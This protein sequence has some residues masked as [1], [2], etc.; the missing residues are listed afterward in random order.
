MIRRR[1]GDEFFLI[2]QHDHAL[3]SG[4]LA[5]HVGNKLFEPARSPS[6]I[7]G[8]EL[9]DCGWPLHD[10]E[11]TLNE[12]GLPLDVFESTR[13]I[14]LKV[15]E[16]SAER[17]AERDDYAALLVSLHVLSLSVNASSATQQKHEKFDVSEAKTR[18]EVNR[19]QHNQIERQ[20]QLRRK[21]GLSTDVPLRHGLAEESSDPRERTLHFH[22]RLLQAMDQVSLALCCTQ[23]PS[24]QIRPVLT[25]PGGKQ[26]TLRVRRATPTELLISPWPF[27][28][29][30]IEVTTKYRPV[31]GEAYESVEAFRNRYRSATEGQLTFSLA[32]E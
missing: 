22:F 28:P 23:P 3:L 18:F 16:A 26:M 14:A 11:P 12:Q 5:R 27:G 2:T 30:K 1:V 24:D 4:E 10:D 8:M 31:P 9:H 15:W 13:P 25:Q 19:F 17:A 32:S 29:E 21:L 20:E 7:L 6:A